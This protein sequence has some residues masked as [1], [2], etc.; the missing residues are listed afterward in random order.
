MIIDFHTHVFPDKIAHSTISVLESRGGNKASTDGT[1]DGLLSHM[2]ES[3]V[4]VSVAL[5]VLTKPTQFDSVIKFAQI[6]NERFSGKYTGKIISFAGIHPACEDI[7]S[8]M[9]M[10]KD[11]GLLGVKIHPD[12]QS[13]F[14]DDDGYIQILKCAKDLDL[15]VVTHSGVDD[16]YVGEPI[17]CPPELCAKV[18]EKVGLEKFVL[19]HYGAHKQWQS[20]LDLLCSKN[21]YFDTAFT[22]HEI[23]E[24]LFKAILDKHGDDKVLFATDCP[25]RSMKED[26]EIIKSFNLGEKTLDKIFYKNAKNLLGI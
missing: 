25:W 15:I 22:L 24:D 9:K 2:T 19:G 13:T 6:V 7:P 1:V 10:V 18:I 11:L 4:D 17:K 21:V 16:A 20:V 14:I 8:K 23:N 5:P 26:V 3:G 12:Y